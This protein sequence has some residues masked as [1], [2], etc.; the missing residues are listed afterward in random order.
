MV[1]NVQVNAG[2][3]PIASRRP[4]GLSTGEI[5]AAERSKIIGMLNDLADLKFFAGGAQRRRLEEIEQVLRVALL[6]NDLEARQSGG[7]AAVS[8]A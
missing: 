8:D 7:P 5:L 1:N 2:E 4:L 3:A 6:E